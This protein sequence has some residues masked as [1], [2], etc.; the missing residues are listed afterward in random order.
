[1]KKSSVSGKE[2]HYPN[3]STVIMVEDFLKGLNGRSIK[4]SELKKKLPKQV[5]HNTLM[6][7]LKYLESSGKICVTLEGISWVFVLKKN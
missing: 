4:I 3:L 6:I 1:M 2:G 7:V 5:N